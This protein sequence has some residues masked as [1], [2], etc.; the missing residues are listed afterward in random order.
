MQKIITDAYISFSMF[1][2][3]FILIFGILAIAISFSLEP[4]LSCL[5]RRAGLHHYSCSEW[6]INQTLQLQRLAYEE[7]GTGGKWLHTNDYVPVTEAGQNLALLDLLDPN[8]PRLSAP[9]DLALVDS[10]QKS[11]AGGND[12]DD[13]DDD[14]NNVVDQVS[15]VSNEVVDQGQRQE[16]PDAEEVTAGGSMRYARPGPEVT[17]AHRGL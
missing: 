9:L 10:L 15:V 17:V 7:A 6:S 1:G 16:G 5:Q 8:H 11:S 13:D 14:G 12:D 3:L 2:L 4:I